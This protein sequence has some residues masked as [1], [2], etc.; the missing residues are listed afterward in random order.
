M[1]RRVFEAET[2]DGSK[3]SCDLDWEQICV[4]VVRVAITI[5][6]WEVFF[7]GMLE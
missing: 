6:I 4:G 5:A 1:K 2:K 3:Y 7:R